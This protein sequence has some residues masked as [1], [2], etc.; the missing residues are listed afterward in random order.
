MSFERDLQRGQTTELRVRQW[1]ERAGIFTLPAIGRNPAYDL[2]I[3]ATLEI[4]RDDAAVRTGNLFLETYSHGEPSGILLSQSTTY[5]FVTGSVCCLVSVDLLKS[6]LRELQERFVADGQKT[7]RILPIRTLR[8][9]PHQR[10]ELGE[11][12]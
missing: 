2:G 5:A 3:R 4:K 11:L 10:I 9:M 6:K 7:G 8:E 12:V 1:W